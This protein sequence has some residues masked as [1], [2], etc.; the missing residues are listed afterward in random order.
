VKDKDKLAFDCNV[1]NSHEKGYGGFPSEIPSG[2][3]IRQIVYN[4]QLHN[5]RPIFYSED[6]F[7]PQDFENVSSVLAGK[8][9]V[10]SESGHLL[11][12]TTPYTI[13]VHTGNGDF[14]VKLD[15]KNWYAGAGEGVIVPSGEHKLELTNNQNDTN[16]I[17]ILS[18]S[19]ELKNAEFSKNTL[20]L[21]YSENTGPCYLTIDRKPA[22]ITIDQTKANCE[23]FKAASGVFTIKFPEGE[24]KVKINQ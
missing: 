3:E 20:A 1:V 18:I 2:E 10:I 19:G 9:K 23:V 13:T 22:Q 14:A 16:A 24:H 5:S 17:H 4:M 12:I 6:A 21:S 8:A 15:G 11:K 7:Y